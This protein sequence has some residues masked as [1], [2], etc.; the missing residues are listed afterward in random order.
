MNP[1][2]N[3]IRNHVSVR[4][5][6]DETLSAEQ[7]KTLV[8]AAQAAS[9]AS[10]QQ[11]YAIIGIDDP[12]LRQKIMPLADG[13]SF[14]GKGGNLF[15]FCGDFNRHAKMAERVAIPITETIEGIDAVMVGAI[16]ASLAAQN[17]VIA[18]ESMG[19]GVCFS[20]GIRDGIEGISPLLNIPDHVTPLFGLVIG[21]PTEKNDLKPRLP[22]EE[23][24]HVNGYQQKL[25]ELMAKYEEETAHYYATRNGHKKPGSW[26]QT[27]LGSLRR[28]PRT[29]MKDYLN[30]HGWAKH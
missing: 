1:T 12:A 27:A 18:A 10:Y 4:S 7:I 25:A 19:L 16:D 28:L 13:Q 23:V 5:F 8:L 29:F 14:V 11:A 3:L 6:T 30:R 15:I 22:F 17:M 2:I 20:G 26:A 24:Y 21:Y 9:T